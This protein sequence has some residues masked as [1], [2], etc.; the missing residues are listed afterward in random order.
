MLANNVTSESWSIT[1]SPSQQWI[2]LRGLARQ[3]GDGFRP[4]WC[5][6]R[7]VIFAARR[8]LAGSRLPLPR[9]PRPRPAATPQQR[10]PREPR[11]RRPARNAHVRRRPRP[12]P[13]Q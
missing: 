8:V 3:P 12:R 1:T 11:P 13:A 2:T 9:P 5:H 10:Q 4:E 7:V 6:T